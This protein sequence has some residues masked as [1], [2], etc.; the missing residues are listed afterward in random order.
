MT[1][2]TPS[3]EELQAMKDASGLSQPKLAALV[4]ISRP[5][6]SD[7]FTG[8][9]RITKSHARLL[10]IICEALRTGRKLPEKLGD[11]EPD[12][13]ETLRQPTATPV[14][15]K[16]VEP[17][18]QSYP[19]LRGIAARMSHCLEGAV[20]LA[21]QAERYGLKESALPQW[22]NTLKEAQALMGSETVPEPEPE[23]QESMT[24]GESQRWTK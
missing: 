4:G 1:K 16:A 7:W 6:M 20:S 22:K 18:P 12:P 10:L 2:Q 3:P 17:E 8:K 15:V 11:W 24:S 14:P 19:D 5:R 13:V 21:L 9:R 23:P